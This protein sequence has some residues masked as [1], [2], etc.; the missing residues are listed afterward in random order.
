MRRTVS[1]IAAIFVAAVVL[2]ACGSSKSS[3]SP[4]AG[5]T[6]TAPGGSPTSSKPE[7]SPNGDISDSAVYVVQA[8]PA[9]KYTIKVPEGWA[10]TTSGGAISF[11]DKLNTIRVETVPAAA[12]PT[13]ASATSTEQPQIA[14]TA[15][16][17][18]AGKVTL[19]SRKSGPAV[20]ITYQATSAPNAVTGKTIGLAVER[21]EL[22]K[23][24]T[25]AIVTL[26]G[27]TGA[28]NVDPWKIVTDSFTWK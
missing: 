27:P 9:G 1:A 6:T 20:L 7:V 10:R 12:A 23:N 4:G 15:S 19:V 21:Y 5:S 25:E 13:V 3:S 11:T 16:G 2:G 28:D 17:Y 8:D 14:Q 26:S 24:G 18:K 22:W